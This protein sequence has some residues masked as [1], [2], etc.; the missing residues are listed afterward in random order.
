MTP[1]QKA[2]LDILEDSKWTAYELDEY[3]SRLHGEASYSAVQVLSPT[4]IDRIK[5]LLKLPNN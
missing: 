1:E 4:C 2:I 3:S 5:M